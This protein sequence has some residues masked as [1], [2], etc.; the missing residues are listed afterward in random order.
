MRPFMQLLIELL[1]LKAGGRLSQ[2]C[3]SHAC[4]SARLLTAHIAELSLTYCVGPLAPS[5][6]RPASIFNGSRCSTGMLPILYALPKS[7]TPL[8][9][10]ALL[11]WSLAVWVSFLPLIVNH[12]DKSPN[13]RST[14]TLQ[15]IT[16]FL[17]GIMLCTAVLLGEKIG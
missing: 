14:N 12:S 15:F 5:C 2:L 13:T 3:K 11:G 8:R 9:Y 17:F 1:R 6:I 16:R 10:I 7:N 4:L